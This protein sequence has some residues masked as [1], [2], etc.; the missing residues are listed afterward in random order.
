[1]ESLFLDVGEAVGDQPAVFVAEEGLPFSS[2]DGG[3]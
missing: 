2:G 1:M 3:Q